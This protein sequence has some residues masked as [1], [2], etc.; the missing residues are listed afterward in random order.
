MSATSNDAGDDYIN[1]FVDGFGLFVVDDE[2]SNFKFRHFDL[3]SIF[4]NRPPPFVVDDE[5]VVTPD[6][7]FTY[8]QHIEGTSCPSFLENLLKA[9]QIKQIGKG[10]HGVAYL[11]KGNPSFIIKIINDHDL[12]YIDNPKQ[13]SLTNKHINID[14][15]TSRFGY[16]KGVYY[17]KKFEDECRGDINE[18]TSPSTPPSSSSP[19]KVMKC[20]NDFIVE[21]GIA[22]C[23]NELFARRSSPCFFPMFL[24]GYCNF[25]GETTRLKKNM[26]DMNINEIRRLIGPHFMMATE[27]IDKGED[28]IH[29]ISTS[30]QG[31]DKIKDWLGT[32]IGWG[33]FTPNQFVFIFTS[34]LHA[35]YEYQTM[36]I[37]HADLNYAHSNIL[38]QQRDAS[39]LVEYNPNITLRYGDK[40]LTFDET[41]TE[42]IPKIGDWGWARKYHPITK[43]LQ[44]GL[45]FIAKNHVS[46]E[47]FRDVIDVLEMLLGFVNIRISIV[48][49]EKEEENLKFDK[50]GIPVFDEREN[51]YKSFRVS[52]GDDV[53]NQIPIIK[54]YFLLSPVKEIYR[55]VFGKYMKTWGM[56]QQFEQE[57]KKSGL[58]DD[59]DDVM[60]VL[61]YKLITNDYSRKLTQKNRS[62]SSSPF[63]HVSGEACMKILF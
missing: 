8:L 26:K 12:K 38:L 28:K 24:G 34:I 22:T 46:F 45:H 43:E 61:M 9:S 42:F 11:L 18:Y 54:K 14:E 39:S 53:A 10:Y 44:I 31:Q 63:S 55:F 58:F 41:S 30:Y 32:R 15:Y 1:S 21:L 37:V 27:F 51:E 19:V 57:I 20:H 40:T 13:L 62:D 36:G 50:R 48:P 5:L 59:D 60:E 33:V 7:I 23:I 17:S 25:I 3:H 16:K 29:P 2:E 4:N 47:P 49:N 52:F 35:I 6:N 56:K